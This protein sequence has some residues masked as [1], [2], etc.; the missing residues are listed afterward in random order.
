VAALAQSFAHE[1]LDLVTLQQ[2]HTWKD[3]I[4]VAEGDATRQHVKVPVSK[5]TFDLERMLKRVHDLPDDG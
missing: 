1:D 5:R 4:Q 2:T 3:E